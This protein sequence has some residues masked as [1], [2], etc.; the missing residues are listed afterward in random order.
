MLCKHAGMNQR[1]AADE[2]GYG[3]GASVSYQLKRLHA[4]MQEDKKLQKQFARIEQQ[5]AE[6]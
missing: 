5:I 1:E 6:G 3:T 2:L 4:M